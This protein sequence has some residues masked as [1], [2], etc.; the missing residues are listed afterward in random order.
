MPTIN[1]ISA[2]KKWLSIS[3]MVIGWLASHCAMGTFSCW[4]ASAKAEHADVVINNYSDKAKVRPVIF[5]HWFHR[6]RYAY[7]M[8]ES[9][10]QPHMLEP[11]VIKL[12]P[13][14]IKK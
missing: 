1:L 11:L 14:A 5:P 9:T 8:H 12:E 6:I 3:K 10:T 2:Y 7:L 4:N 13:L